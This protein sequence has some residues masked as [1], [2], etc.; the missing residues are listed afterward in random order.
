MLTYHAT[1]GE[2]LTDALLADLRVSDTIEMACL[3]PGRSLRELLQESVKDS[4]WSYQVNHKET[5][6]V[7]FGVSRQ[8]NP[9]MVATT[10]FEND[11]KLRI[12]FLR[13]CPQ[14]I[15][16]MGEPFPYLWNVTHVDNHMTHRWLKRMGFTLCS[17]TGPYQLFYKWS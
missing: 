14:W 5:P 6:L 16:R 3:Y 15:A 9:W 2:V 4:L 17:P 11:R 8:G 13:E 12:R 1:P 10:Y 7:L